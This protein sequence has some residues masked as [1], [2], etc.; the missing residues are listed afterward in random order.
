MV[1]KE[2][3]K[4]YIRLTEEIDSLEEMI[5]RLQSKK[6]SIGAAK[7]SAAAS[8]SA[9]PDKMASNMAR[10]DELQNRYHEKLEYWLMQQQIITEAID[11]LPERE[12]LLMRY[13]YLMGMEWEQ[14]AA[15]MR[16]S[17]RQT[18]RIHASALKILKD[19]TQW[20]T[21]S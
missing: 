13:R 18:H 2:D 14:I 7:L 3:L 12:Q 10:L 1:T 19:G 17:W 4:A 8:G 15:K 20:H 5:E 6:D 11:S 9:T 21:N 16:Y